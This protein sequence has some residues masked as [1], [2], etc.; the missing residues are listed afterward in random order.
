MSAVL[1]Y[2]QSAV[3]LAWAVPDVAPDMWRVHTPDGWLS[4]MVNLTRAKDAAVQICAR[5]PPVLNPRRFRWEASDGPSEVTEE[6]A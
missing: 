2:G 1:Y 3:P 5:G 4:D 6:A